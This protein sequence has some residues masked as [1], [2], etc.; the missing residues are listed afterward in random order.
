MTCLIPSEHH[1]H[2][3]HAEGHRGHGEEVDGDEVPDMVVEE[4]PPGR[5][6]RSPTAMH[7]L[8]D[9]GLS[10]I[11]AELEQ[12]AVDSGR[13]P[14]WVGDTHSPDQGPDPGVEGRSAGTATPT[15][16]TPVEPK[17]LPVPPD[18]GL[19]L[20]DD[21]AGTPLP[22]E[23]AEPGPE[24]PVAPALPGTLHAPPKDRQLLAESKILRHQPNPITRDGTEQDAEGGQEA[25]RRLRLEA[26]PGF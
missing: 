21:E 9:G 4:G 26:K 24:D 2:E 11:D 16:P 8:G 13:S 12:L 23:A 10:D 19:G 15:L 1:E 6:G 22:P 5:R 18:H 3:E 25:H 17:A 14:G 7:V 20:D